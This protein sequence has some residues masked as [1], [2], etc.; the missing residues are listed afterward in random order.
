M[1]IECH[2][3]VSSISRSLGGSLSLGAREE[4]EGVAITS[5]VDIVVFLEMQDMMPT[6]LVVLIRGRWKKMVVM[7]S[8]YLIK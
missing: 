5:G 6:S 3:S 8:G 2:G 1:S 7:D 4:E